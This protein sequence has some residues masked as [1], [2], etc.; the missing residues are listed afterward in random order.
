MKR[1]LAFVLAF[2]L[3]LSLVSC[4]ANKAPAQA[5]PVFAIE[6]DAYQCTPDELV[7]ALRQEI[8][9]VDGVYF[10]PREIPLP[11]EKGPDGIGN[12]KYAI[13]PKR[14][15]IDI[16]TDDYGNVDNIQL[17][18]AATQEANDN[19]TLIAFALVH[20]LMPTNADEVIEDFGYALTDD[21]TCRKVSDGTSFFFYGHESSGFYLWISPS[22]SADPQVSDAI[23]E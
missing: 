16:W 21:V 17:N 15:I 1:I 8:D 5:G 14:L 10:T 2:T 23:D 6:N 4:T 13:I 19:A 3:A 9:H 20:M 11:S 22:V 7:L 12:Y 18:W